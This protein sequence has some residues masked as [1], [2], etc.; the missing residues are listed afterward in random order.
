MTELLVI[1][2]GIQIV[3]MVMLIWI[4]WKIFKVTLILLEINEKI[5]GI[6]QTIATHGTE[7]ND[8][9]SNLRLPRAYR[10]VKNK[11]TSD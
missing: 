11:H 9:L 4:N 5:F 3:G 10:E 2:M 7:M 6:T 1:F 8:S